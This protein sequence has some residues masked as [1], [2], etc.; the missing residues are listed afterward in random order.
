MLAG[1]RNQKRRRKSEN[2]QPPTPKLTYTTPRDLVIF[3]Y[4]PQ[5]QDIHPKM[6]MQPYFVRK[7]INFGT[8]QHCIDSSAGRGLIEASTQIFPA[9]ICTFALFFMCLEMYDLV[10]LLFLL[11]GATYIY[12]A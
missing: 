9:G 10:D 3:E 12:F 5:N 4:N 6:R 8:L 11:V 1:K 7:I 2:T